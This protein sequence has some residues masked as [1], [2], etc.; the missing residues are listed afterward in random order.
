MRFHALLFWRYRELCAFARTP[1]SLC[2]QTKGASPLSLWLTKWACW[3]VEAGQEADLQSSS[4]RSRVEP[5]G[6]ATSHSGDAPSAKLWVVLERWVASGKRCAQEVVHFF[7]VRV[8]TC[9]ALGASM[10]QASQLRRPETPEPFKPVATPRQQQL[11]ASEKLPSVRL[12]HAT[13]V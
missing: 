4:C 2:H 8:L 7:V 5:R 6:A 11:E 12:L 13:V 9:R 3:T 1:G 10:T